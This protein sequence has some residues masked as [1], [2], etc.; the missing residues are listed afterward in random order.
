MQDTTFRLFERISI[1]LEAEE[2]KGCTARGLKLVHVRI[3]D[4][5]AN[6]TSHSNTPLAVA[7]YLCLTKGTVSQS[8]SLLE[9]KGYVEKI[10]DTEDKRVVHLHLST[11][12]KLLLAE[13]KPLNIFAEAE[14][15]LAS[16][17]VK[18]VGD[19]L[20]AVLQVLQQ[21]GHTKSFGICASCLHLIEQEEDHYHCTRSQLSVSQDDT[22]KICRHHVPFE[23]A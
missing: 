16:K 4:Y 23:N 1:L 14:Q 7:E 12:G 19:A 9:R 22:E 17:Q 18:T 5:L 8:I 11:M 13:L 10:P 15:L 21:T 6:C 2:R 20:N 3:L